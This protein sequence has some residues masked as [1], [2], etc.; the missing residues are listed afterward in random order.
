VWLRRAAA[1][2]SAMLLAMRRAAFIL[3]LAILGEG[4]RDSRDK[5]DNR[6]RNQK[7]A[8]QIG[9]FIANA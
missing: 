9:P 6:G 2:G 7:F 3:M 1:L 4:G 8:H 5:A